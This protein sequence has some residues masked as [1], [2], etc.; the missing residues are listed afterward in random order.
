MN[1]QSTAGFEGSK[2]ILCDTITGI[3]VIIHLSKP[4]E[5]ATPGMNPNVAMDTG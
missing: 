3:H 4:I 2:T 5:C 1:R